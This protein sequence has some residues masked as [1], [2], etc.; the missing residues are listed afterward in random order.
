MFDMKKQM[1]GMRVG[2][3]LMLINLS[4][5]KNEKM[6]TKLHDVSWQWV[7][8]NIAASHL[9]PSAQQFSKLTR[10]LHLISNFSPK[11]L[12]PAVAFF[13]SYVYLSSSSTKCIK[14]DFFNSFS[15]YQRQQL[16]ASFFLQEA[17]S[18][19]SVS[20]AKSFH[21]YPRQIRITYVLDH[22]FLCPP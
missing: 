22:C 14:S 20:F 12:D 18:I 11:S 5:R 8:R 1:P 10:V 3:P 9:L 15:S 19:I 21:R 17:I 16:S 2:N 4:R 13:I 6:N 7:K